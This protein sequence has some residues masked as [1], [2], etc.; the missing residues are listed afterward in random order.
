MTNNEILALFAG[1]PGH[2][3]SKTFIHSGYKYATDGK[4]IARCPTLEVDNDFGVRKDI[5][6]TASDPAWW[7][8]S[9]Q[10]ANVPEFVPPEPDKCK[11]CDGSGTLKKCL[12]CNGKG[13]VGVT[14][15][16]KDNS[17]YDIDA[18]C[19][20]CENWPSPSSGKCENCEGKGSFWAH[21]QCTNVFGVSIADE[22]LARLHRIGAEIRTA[23]IL[24]MVWP[25]GHKVVFFAGEI[26]GIVI[27]TSS[28]YFAKQLVFADAVGSV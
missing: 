4:T 12:D 20:V 9:E 25:E 27:P 26:R 14:Y 24:G 28:E 16:A 6:K 5:I 23:N 18:D 8:W 7:E 13:I 10:S 19:P 3:N 15:T 1:E 21:N 2:Y 22:Y 11:N 17:S